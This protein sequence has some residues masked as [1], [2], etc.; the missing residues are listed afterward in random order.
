MEILLGEEH[1][2]KLGIL[3]AEGLPSEWQLR[4]EPEVYAKHS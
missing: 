4:I 1:P 2:I 3:L